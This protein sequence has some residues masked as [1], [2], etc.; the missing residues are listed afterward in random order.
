M[1]QVMMFDATVQDN[2]TI[3]IDDPV[4]GAWTAAVLDFTRDSRRN[5]GDMTPFN[6]GNR[7]DDIFFFPG[8]VSPGEA[9]LLLD[10]VVLYD[11]GVDE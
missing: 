3:R 2:R 1:V 7:V 5:S 10:E 8:F 4:L 9:E 11:A 6:P